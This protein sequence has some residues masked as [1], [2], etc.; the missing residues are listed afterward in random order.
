MLNEVEICSYKL[1]INTNETHYAWREVHK[2]VAE[3]ALHL[4]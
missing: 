2:E 4:D 1:P 3:I